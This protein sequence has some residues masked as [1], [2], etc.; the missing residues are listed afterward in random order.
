MANTTSWAF[1]N[2]IDPIRNQVSVLTD[3][4]SVVNRS[5]LLMLSDPTSLHYNPTFG[6]GLKKYLWQYNTSNTKARMKDNIKEQ[7]REHEPC[8]IADDCQFEDGLLFSE[9]TPSEENFN[10]IKMTIGLRTIFG[11]DLSIELD[12]EGQIID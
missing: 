6:V 4:A 2:M 1:P 10:Q 11:D 5:R 7:L 12:N 9:E 8:V 3:N